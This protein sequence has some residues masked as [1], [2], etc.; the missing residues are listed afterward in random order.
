MAWGPSQAV[1]PITR[2]TGAKHG[3]DAGTKQK[4]EMTMRNPKIITLTALMAA[5]ALAA[6][7][8]ADT[9]NGHSTGALRNV[10]NNNTPQAGTA[11]GGVWKT[12]DGGA[13]GMADG[14]VRT[15]IT[16][17][18]SNADP[19][20]QYLGRDAGGQQGA[21]N[22]LIGLL[23]TDPTGRKSGGM[24]TD[25]MPTD[26]RPNLVGE[27][28]GSVLNRPADSGEAQGF[29]WGLKP[30]DTGASGDGSVRYRPFALV[31][32]TGIV[33]PNDKNAGA[34][35]QAYGD[36]LGRDTGGAA[37]GKGTG[38]TFTVTFGGSLVGMADGSVRQ[39]GG[40]ALGKLD[41]VRSVDGLFNNSRGGDQSNGPAVQTGLAYATLTV[42]G[43]S[44]NSAHGAGGGGGAGKA[45]FQDLSFSTRAVVPEPP[46]RI[47]FT[48]G[49]NASGGGGGA[50]KGPDVKVVNVGNPTLAKSLTAGGGPHVSPAGKTANIVIAPK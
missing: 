3:G 8:S 4:T 19:Y 32:R 49:V 26:Q 36:V 28:F 20:K 2:R 45:T 29:S 1:K 7:A 6:P 17:G 13:S 35:Q 34:V 18:T 38:S 23:Q 48:N 24:P 15:G 30:V 16:D 37:Q 27:V 12:T 21:A 33:D 41:G 10:S 25:Q 44:G 43:A 9:F 22:G 47:N 46:E 31:D 40:S 50:G 39:P 11:N 42:G 5:I 14:S